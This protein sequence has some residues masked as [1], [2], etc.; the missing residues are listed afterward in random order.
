MENGT[1]PSQSKVKAFITQIEST[2]KVSEIDNLFVA[3]FTS[4][5]AEDAAPVAGSSTNFTTRD[6]A[7][8]SSE[9]ED[10][11]D[12]NLSRKSNSSQPQPQPTSPK[13]QREV[14]VVHLAEP[15]EEGEVSNKVPGGGSCPQPQPQPQPAGGRCP[16]CR[17]NF[18]TID[19]LEVH[20]SGCMQENS[21]SLKSC[22]VLLKNIKCGENKANS[23]EKI[24]P[25]K[26]PKHT[27][28]YLVPGPK[29]F[30]V[31]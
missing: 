24:S 9:D 15:L 14:S 19:K 16:L 6:L 1:E 17:Q 29:I 12:K 8:F 5:S 10:D 20:A 13:Q 22:F 18:P 2:E 27:I 26:K 7:F 3:M 4:S 11:G 31:I 28:P 21:F 30:T 23:Q 25:S